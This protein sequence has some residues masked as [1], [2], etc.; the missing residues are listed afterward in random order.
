MTDRKWE[1]SESF[2]AVS[3]NENGYTVGI[4]STILIEMITFCFASLSVF[5]V[6]WV[7]IL[8]FTE[9]NLFDVSAPS[10]GGYKIRMFGQLEIIPKVLQPHFLFTESSKIRLCVKTGERIESTQSENDQITT[11]LLQ[12]EYQQL[13]SV[14]SSQRSARSCNVS[15]WSLGQWGG[16]LSVVDCNG[17]QTVRNQ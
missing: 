5:Y 6:E 14:P 10:E 3:R 17:I 12:G 2:C 8:I 7:K 11:E 16:T 13:D 9:L 4:V 15:S 1:L